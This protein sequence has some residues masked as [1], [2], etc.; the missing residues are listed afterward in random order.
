MEEPPLNVPGNVNAAIQVA[1]YLVTKKVVILVP[2]K[3][4]FIVK[5]NGTK[6]MVQFGPYTCSCGACYCHHIFDARISCGFKTKIR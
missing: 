3:G 1:Q 6:H 5:E 2:D 4:L